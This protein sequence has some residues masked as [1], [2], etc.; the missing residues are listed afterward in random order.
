MSPP[1]EVNYARLLGFRK[2]LRT[3]LRWSDEKAREVGLTPAQHQLLLSVRGRDDSDPTIGDIADDLMLRHHSTVELVDRAQAAGLVNRRQDA[4][5][6]RVIRVR[7]TRRGERLLRELSDSHL[8][9]IR[10]LA[11]IVESLA[12]D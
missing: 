11:P 7:L 1:T 10:R 5:D 8:R 6:R 12:G 9:E 3:F 2:A 4:T